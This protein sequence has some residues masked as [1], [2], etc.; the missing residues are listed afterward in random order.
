MTSYARLGLQLPEPPT[1]DIDIQDIIET[2]YLV[3]RGRNYIDGQPMGLSV[4]D[5]TEV[6]TAHPV[7]IP[8]D[9]LDKVIF[10]IDDMVLSEK[11][12]PRQ[13]S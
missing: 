8:R 12:K 2:Y 7:A 13:D 9:V 1:Y 4:K 5:I 3:V 10:A 11:R 6:V